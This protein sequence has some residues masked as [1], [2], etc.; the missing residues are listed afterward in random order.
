MTEHLSHISTPTGFMMVLCEGDD[1]I[2]RLE[3]LMRDETIPSASV[4]GFGFVALARFGFFDY[5]RQDYEPREFNDLEIVGLTGS[6]AWM[7]G[8]PSVHAHASGGDRDFRIV[9]GH[10]LG[11][12]V[13]RGSFEITVI[14]HACRLDRRV[15]PKIGAKVLTL[16]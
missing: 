12:T 5:D 3:T 16:K 1:V 15:D 14:V 6:L 10:V 11:L 4:A 9:G 2:A 7:D 8:R 13:G